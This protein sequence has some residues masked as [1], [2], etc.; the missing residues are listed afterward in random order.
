MKYH[1]TYRITHI[2][3][4]K[5]YYGTRTSTINPKEDI[6]I[7]YFSSSS[8]KEFIKDQKEHPQNYK[9]KVLKVFSTREEAMELEIK[10]HNKF[11]VG[12]NEHFYNRAKQTSTGF[13]FSGAKHSIE[14]K[15]QIR[16]KL[17]NKKRPFDVCKKI[18]KGRNKIQ[19]NGKTVAENSASK[20]ATN[21]IKNGTVNIQKGIK[22]NNAKTIHIF[23]KQHELMFECKGNFNETCKSNNL[24]M[25]AL[26]RSYQKETILISSKITKFNE[27]FDGWYAKVIK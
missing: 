17:V 8:N 19:S 5:Y 14:T 6:G 27:K 11:D 4:K 1:Y 21:R 18:S 20:I 9:Y 10:L 12:V 24:L 2:E 25:S 7:K 16:L 26:T 3:H 15:T 23:N 13:D 22:N